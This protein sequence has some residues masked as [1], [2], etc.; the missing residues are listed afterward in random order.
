[1]KKWNKGWTQLGVELWA[2]PEN[3]EDIVKKTE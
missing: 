2:A 1:M 3:I